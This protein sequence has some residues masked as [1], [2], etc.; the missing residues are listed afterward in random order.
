[1][2]N[3]CGSEEQEIDYTDVT[4][5]LNTLTTSIDELVK[6]VTQMIA[7]QTLSIKLMMKIVTEE[8]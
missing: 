3:I 7:L 4:M 1:M 6:V 8:N 5:A 2:D